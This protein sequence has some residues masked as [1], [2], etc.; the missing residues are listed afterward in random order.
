MGIED[1]SRTTLRSNLWTA[2][3]QGIIGREEYVRI[4]RDG[5][6][7]EARV[8]DLYIKALERQS[9]IDRWAERTNLAL[10]GPLEERELKELV[11]ACNE[12]LA[13]IKRS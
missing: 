9:R 5:F 13:E 12:E 1:E 8:H 4:I 2:L 3:E 6:P 7:D 10:G 11:L